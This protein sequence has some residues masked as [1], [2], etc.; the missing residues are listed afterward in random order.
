MIALIQRVKR[1]NVTV[2]DR[3]TGSIEEGLLIFLGVHTTDSAEL[4]PWVARKCVNLRVFP[5]EDG[6]MNRSLL[7]HQGEILVVSQFTLYGNAEKGNRPSFIESAGAAVAEPLYESFC[8]EL[9]TQME[10]P[11]QRGE[12]GAMMDVDLVNW[13]PVTISIEKRN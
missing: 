7:D 2:G 6:K 13:G 4:I 10:R 5:D 12:F 11:I 3:L 8:E 9:E 1:A